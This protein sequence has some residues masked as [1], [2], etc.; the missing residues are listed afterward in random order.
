MKRRFEIGSRKFSAHIAIF[1]NDEYQRTP[2]GIQIDQTDPNTIIVA[3]M[4]TTNINLGANLPGE[5]SFRQKN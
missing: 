1:P 3:M 5:L 2:S 4:G